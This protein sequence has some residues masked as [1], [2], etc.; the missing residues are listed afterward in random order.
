M[1]LYVRQKNI[2][3]KKCEVRTSKGGKLYYLV[4]DDEGEVYGDWR[5]GLK[6][7][8]EF[9]LRIGVRYGIEWT[10]SENGLYKNIYSAYE[11]GNEQ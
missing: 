7:R 6:Y 3:V 9:P 5:D 11:V 1:N 4:T 8:G 10:R 2:T